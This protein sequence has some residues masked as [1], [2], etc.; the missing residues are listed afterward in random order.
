MPSEDL[1]DKR[2]VVEKVSANYRTRHGTVTG[3]D[4]VSLSV[5]KSQIVGI[6]GESGSGKSTLA[7]V[8]VGLV[9]ADSGQVLID[10][11]VLRDG[12]SKMRLAHR[13]RWKMQMI[14]QD[15]YSS[16]NPRQR[17]WEAVAEALHVWAGDNRKVARERA[18]ELLASVGISSSQ[19]DRYP[20][21]LS[22]GQR[23][24]VSIARAL[25]PNPLVLLA[26]E[27]TSSID[28]SAQAQILNLLR[29]LQQ[30]RGMTIV[31]ISHD[32]SVVRYLASYTHVMRGGRVIESGPS[33]EVFSRP[34]DEYTQRLVES[35]PGRSS[36][37][38]ERP[39]GTV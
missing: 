7:K 17:A 3:V 39:L 27:P 1:T 8:L 33:E 32:L 22:G 38:A 37:R 25:A 4:S 18:V 14:F 15:P 11:A 6:V 5:A 20:H 10:G 29:E 16:L 31:F 36:F 21:A 30:E 34:R 19:A 2:L 26:D 23:Q 28:R 24:R 35:I 9:P 12:R 13:D